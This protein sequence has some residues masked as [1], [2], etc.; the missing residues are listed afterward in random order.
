[1]LAKIGNAHLFSSNNNKISLFLKDLKTAEFMQKQISAKPHNVLD[2]TAGFLRLNYK[3]P[4]HTISL[5]L[6]TD[7]KLFWSE[8]QK[9]ALVLCTI[10]HI[11]IAMPK[12]KINYCQHAY[13]IDI[14]DKI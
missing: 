9:S 4:Q 10:K 1:M 11:E 14:N 8:I 5:K 3:S 13:R 7:K 2:R 6:C 12:N